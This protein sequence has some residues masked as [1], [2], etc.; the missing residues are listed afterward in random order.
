MQARAGLTRRDLCRA[1]LWACCAP[2]SLGGCARLPWRGGGDAAMLL[3]MTGEAAALGQNMA[4]AAGLVVPE[5][6]GQALVFDTTD[7]ADGARSAADR[8]LAGGARMLLGP[9]RADQTPAVLAV[10]G[11]VPVVTFSNDDRLTAEGA[12]VMG[13][14]PAQS[15]AAA[16]SYARSQGVRRV[17]VVAAPGPLGEATAT[18]ARQLAGAG[19]LALTAVLT[20]DPSAPDLA[21]ALSAASGGTLPDAVFLPDGGGNLTAFADVLSGAG[22]QLMGGVQWGVTDV[23]GIPS[24]GGAWFAAPPPDRFMP[25]LDTFQT[26]FGQEAGIVTALGHDAALIAATLGGDGALDRAGLTRSEGFDGVLGRFRFLEDGRCAR[27]L[28]VLT[29]EGGQIVAIGEVTGT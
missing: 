15:V 21:A 1:T 2:L 10:A 11:D 23:A 24:L 14:T 8:A 9:L 3:P 16:F 20:R 13:I 28:A 12:F 26:R 19:G 27:D 5:G 7:T 6:S 18:A 17:A 29:I 22:L 4:R 25:F